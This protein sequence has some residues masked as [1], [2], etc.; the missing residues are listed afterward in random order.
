[1][2]CSRGLSKE[3][4]CALLD[5]DKD[6]KTV[7]RKT[8][9]GR[10]ALHF[11][12][13]MRLDDVIEVLLQADTKLNNTDVDFNSDDDDIYQI[14]HGI[15]PL[16]YA[17][18][19][20]GICKTVRLLLEKDCRHTT[21]FQCIGTAFTSNLNKGSGGKA[22]FPRKRFSELTDRSLY[23]RKSNLRP[24][25]MS[26]SKGMRPLHIALAQ[27]SVEISRL[28]LLHE[29]QASKSIDDRQRL[30]VMVDVHGRTCLHF[31]CM[32]N[33]EPDI[34]RNLLELDPSRVSTTLKDDKG[35]TPLHLAC[36]HE[37]ANIETVQ[38]IIDAESEYC[39]NHYI[40]KIK[41]TS[42]V[43]MDRL[44]P[45][46][47]AIL[48][49]GPNN[50]I[51]LLLKPTYFDMT[52]MG[53]ALR[54]KL[55]QRVQ[56]HAPLQRALNLTLAQRD[57]FVWLFYNLFINAVALNAFIY[58]IEPDFNL[59]KDTIPFGALVFSCASFLARELIQIA[60]QKSRYLVD[61]QNLFDLLNVS[62]MVM[63]VVYVLIDDQNRTEGFDSSKRL[64]LISCSILLCTHTVFSLRS[65]FLPF[66]RFARGTEVILVTL[67]PFFVTT[68]I[69]LL[70]FVLVFRIHHLPKDDGTG[71][72]CEK[73]TSPSLSCMC[74]E[75]TTEC[76]TAVLH[77]FFS[78]P[79]SCHYD[80]FPYRY[81]IRH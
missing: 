71:T 68:A 17:C 62:F 30:A 13:E 39:T 45:L 12:L 33:M 69:M 55:A 27:G 38:M 14:Y 65:T 81:Q 74:R 42:A 29:K 1:M 2:A 70:M 40:D 19:L 46:S 75:S 64:V 26:P 60:A 18:S 59:K 50:V 77:G 36:M 37:S 79:V 4:V 10:N 54:T 20:N 48:A 16:H 76:M 22:S 57:S 31:A 51:E 66:A 28:V 3:I 7:R 25:S 24:D 23:F 11:A 5:A 32:Q 52:G 34:I 67:I 41:S 80:P 49:K 78:G 56:R 73:E 6:G 72:K 61:K 9:N 47:V 43:N 15:L 63:S 35:C 53:P 8:Q 21:I 58:V 44:N